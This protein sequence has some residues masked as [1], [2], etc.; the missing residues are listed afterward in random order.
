MSSAARS[1]R[2]GSS[3]CA[4][5]APNSAS[6]AS[7]MNL[8]TKPSNSCT[9]AVSSSKSSF[10]RASSEFRVEPLAERR[11]A[12]EIGEKHRHRAAVGLRV[13]A[14]GRRWLLAAAVES[15]RGR[16]GGFGGRHRR[17]IG[18]LERLGRADFP[19]ASR[20]ENEVRRT[21]IAAAGTRRR[22]LCTASRAVGKTALD[23]KTAGSTIHRCR[24]SMDLSR[25]A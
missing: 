15:R 5:G 22:L 7:P 9:A 20:A 23:F 11:K 12:A 14:P 1:A 3:S 10:C 13:A 4:T 25:L 21:R 18:F 19:A 2:S 16:A 17:S 24:P 8:S 6:R